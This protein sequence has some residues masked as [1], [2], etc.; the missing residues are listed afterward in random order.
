[1]P[2]AAIILAVAG[3]LGFAG[4]GDDTTGATADLAAV[5]DLAV[6]SD[7]L[8]LSCAEVLSCVHNCGQNEACRQGCI[9]AATADG[10]SRFDAF[11]GCV[12]QSCSG[13]DGGSGSC[14]S[15][16]DHSIGCTT[17]LQ[18]VADDATTTGRACHAE[19]ADCL[20]H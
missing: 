6:S 9:D 5:G 18:S 19:Y 20:A 17:C 13:V 16:T 1:M 3:L 8:Q 7:M 11:D 14:D 10:K 4:C 15:P 2:R 12:V